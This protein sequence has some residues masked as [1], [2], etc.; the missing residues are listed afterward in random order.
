MKK[1]QLL[2]ILTL[3]SITTYSQKVIENVS[4]KIEGKKVSIGT[5]NSQTVSYYIYNIQKP[6]QI[7]SKTTLTN[8]KGTSIAYYPSGSYT[9]KITKN[10][11]TYTTKFIVK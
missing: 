1:I 11:R 3:T 8:I 4:I 7:Y 9:I 2:T 5:I 10:G 6:N